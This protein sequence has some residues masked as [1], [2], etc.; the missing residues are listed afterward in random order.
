MAPLWIGFLALVALLLALDLGVF[1]RKSHVVSLREAGIWT[2]VWITCGLSFAGVVYAIYQNHFLGAHIARESTEGVSAGTL[3]A[4]EYV[5]GY[6]LEKSLSIDNIFVMALVFDTFGVGQK[7]RHRILFWGI[8]GAVALR[9]LMILSGVWLLHQF[10]WIFYVFGAYLLFTGLKLLKSGAEEIDPEQ[11]IFVRTARR[12][13]PIATG[14]HGPRFI[15]RENGRFVFTRLALVLVVIEGTDVVFALD[16][17]PAILS[18]T[19]ETFIVFTSNIFA[20]L[21][22]RSL[23]FVLQGML[24]RFAHLKVALAFILMFIG[25]KM[26]LHS[27]YEIPTLVSLAVILGAIAVGLISSIVLAP[28][29]EPTTPS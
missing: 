20:I 25:A 17:I 1:H 15:T 9:A 3:A 6:L 28:K 8:V 22:L 4:L 13:F 27:I 29:R 19:T 23:Y 12:L 26:I 14:D 24:E 7:Y 11:T 18:I 10:A 21:G 5:T 16:S 2:A